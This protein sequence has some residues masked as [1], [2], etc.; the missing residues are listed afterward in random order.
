MKRV[1]QDEYELSSGR[2]VPSNN[3]II[4]LSPDFD[5]GI[6][7]GYDG[8]VAFPDR[9]VMDDIG[10]KFTYRDHLEVALFMADLWYEYAHYILNKEREE[11][12]K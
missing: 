8:H 12:A 6:F 7:E 5:E 10:R 1:N 9:A 4:G 3:G 11:R 2:T